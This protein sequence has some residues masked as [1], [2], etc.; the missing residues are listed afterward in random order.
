MR[1]QTPREKKLIAPKCYTED[2][3][4]LPQSGA[5]AHSIGPRLTLAQAAEKSSNLPVVQNSL[6]SILFP[7]PLKSA[8]NVLSV[9]AL[10][11]SQ[12]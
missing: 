12:R 2:S 3:T 8:N 4:I 7:E 10:I 11:D 9:L 6:F 1:K 5:K